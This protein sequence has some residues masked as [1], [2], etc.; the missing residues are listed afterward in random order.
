MATGY[1]REK[2]KYPGVFFVERGASKLLYILYRKPESR[3]LIEEKL[4]ST[5]KGWSPAK[6]SLERARRIG[7]KSINTEKRAQDR[8]CEGC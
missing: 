2:T 4:G 5:T 8:T 3:K 7:G 6:A 1:K